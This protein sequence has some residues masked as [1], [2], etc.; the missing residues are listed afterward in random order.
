MTPQTLAS[1]QSVQERMAG[2]YTPVGVAG[3]ELHKPLNRCFWQ[4]LGPYAH[5]KTRLVQTNPKAL[6]LNLD[7]SPTTHPNPE[8]EIWPAV[9]DQGQTIDTDGSPLVL[10]WPRVMD[11]IE[12]VLKASRANLPGTPECIVFDS[13]PSAVRLC[14]YHTGFKLAAKADE[15]QR[16]GRGK[17]QFELE[18]ITPYDL[19]GMHG[20][21]LYGLTYDVIADTIDKLRHNNKGVGIVTHLDWKQ[22]EKGRTKE[23]EAIMEDRPV[24]SISDALR[25]RIH[26]GL[27]FSF[28]I[29]RVKR[30]EADTIAGEKKVIT[31]G[32]IKKEVA[33]G[34]RQVERLVDKAMI[35]TQD[36]DLDR[37]LK[38]RQGLPIEFP[39]DNW[40]DLEAVYNS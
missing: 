35:I 1:G 5:G 24:L 31:V 34:N 33:T 36:D 38:V 11:V 40:A 9:D 7:E 29:K 23:G 15:I 10:T 16:Q 26:R 6:I 27:D 25:D 14:L 19:R 37:F 20:Q 8:A 13:L 22:F 4:V 28:R 3:R 2:R 39:V 12:H 17:R 21:L 18:D 30:K 32:G